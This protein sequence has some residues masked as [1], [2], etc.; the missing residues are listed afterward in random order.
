[1]LI[2]PS[3]ASGTVSLEK[4]SSELL[5]EKIKKLYARMDMRQDILEQRS[6]LLLEEMN[7]LLEEMNRLLEQRNR[8]LE[9]ENKKLKIFI[10]HLKSRKNLSK[11]ED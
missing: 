2:P 10:Q 1:M 8:S 9:E 4:M 11:L 5:K 6:G 3:M 7:R